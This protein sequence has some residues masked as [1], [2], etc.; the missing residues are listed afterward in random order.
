MP[1]QHRARIFLSKHILD[2]FDVDYAIVNCVYPI[3]GEVHLIC[4]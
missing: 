2:P 3:D 4:P 1:R